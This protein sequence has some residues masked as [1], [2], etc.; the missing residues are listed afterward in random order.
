MQAQLIVIRRSWRE[1]F[2]WFGPLLAL[3]VVLSALNWLTISG[4]NSFGDYIWTGAI[5]VLLVEV[6]AYARMSVTLRDDALVVQNVRRSEIPVGRIRGV[7]VRRGGYFTPYV[8]E[9]LDG[10]HAVAL[11]ATTAGWKRNRPWTD[12]Q[13]EIVGQWWL[14]HG[15]ADHP[16][17]TL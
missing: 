17:A 15:G 7:Q 12:Q 9:V 16:V 2:A 5:V 13:L 8:I 4:A 1:I 6:A 3:F 10:Q 14:A 11:R